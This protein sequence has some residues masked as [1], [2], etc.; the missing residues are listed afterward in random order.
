MKCKYLIYMAVLFSAV[1]C[2]KE[3]SLDY[4]D[5]ASESLVANA[6]A[7][8]DSL[9]S[10]SISNSYAIKDA[11]IKVFRTFIKKYEGDYYYFGA[12]GE[13]WTYPR[14]ILKF[15]FDS[16][17]NA[18]KTYKEYA[19]DQANVRISVNSKDEYG[20]VYNDSSCMYESDYRPKEGDR[21]QL[22]A[23]WYKDSTLY[24]KE[25]VRAEVIV[26]QKT[27]IEI[28]DI[29]YEYKKRPGEWN[30][31]NWQY[32]SGCI[33]TVAFVTLK[34]HDITD[35]KNFYRL[36]VSTYSW[37]Q[38]DRG[39]QWGWYP[40][41]ADRALEPS[42][43]PEDGWF[44]DGDYREISPVGPFVWHR[45]DIYRSK[46]ALFKDDRLVRGF[47][48]WSERF[49]NI[50]DDRLFRDGE[51]IV[52]IETRLMRGTD[53]K[54]RVELQ[55]LSEDYYQF[56][57]SW[58]VYR[59]TSDDDFAESIYIHSNVDNGFGIIGAVNSDVHMMDLKIPQQ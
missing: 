39:D 28:L 8:P 38:F 33:D 51:Y 44:L 43:D 59:I 57:K 2:E 27:Q 19:N 52:E 5:N 26:P 11:P 55:S 31:S 30:G 9:F 22:V 24:E 7:Y 3:F 23:E 41:N 20:F 56:W 15:D 53:R 45:N 10:V 49:S 37:A 50:F 36:K 42:D 25:E 16:T 58:M 35:I 18:S 21:I 14:D 46:D 32:S 6:I 40:P 4:F 1:S 13:E 34:L 48:G 54:L 17:G 12:I 47:S 29:R